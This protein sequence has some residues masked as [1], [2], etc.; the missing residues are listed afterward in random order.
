MFLAAWLTSDGPNPNVIRITIL[1]NPSVQPFPKGFSRKNR[2]L[3]DKIE[4]LKE[5]LCQQLR[6]DT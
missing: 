4:K 1:E 6:P 2:K 3:S 5:G